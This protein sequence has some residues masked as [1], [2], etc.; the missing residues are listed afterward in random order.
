MQN[1]PRSFFTSSIA[2]KLQELDLE[3]IWNSEEKRKTII[4]FM[5]S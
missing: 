3:H 5:L 4:A 2:T 1:K